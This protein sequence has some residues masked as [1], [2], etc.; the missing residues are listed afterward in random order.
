LFGSSQPRWSHD[1]RR[2][3]FVQPDR[4]IMVAAFDAA[5]ATAGP[6]QIFAQT[7]I[8][9]TMFGWF[10]FAVSPDDHLLVNSLPSNTSAPLTLLSGWQSQLGHH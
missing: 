4:K 7:R 8:V 2:L 6:A 3:F 10:Q 5:K 1:G 9:V